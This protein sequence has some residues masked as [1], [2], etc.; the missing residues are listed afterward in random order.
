MRLRRFRVTEYI[1]EC[2]AMFDLFYFPS[3][4]T[5]K[6]W[7]PCILNMSLQN[8]VPIGLCFSSY[9]I[10][11]S[12]TDA[13]QI[14]ACEFFLGTLTI[15]PNAD[16]DSISLEGLQ[17]AGSIHVVDSAH[18]QSISSSTLRALRWW[19][20]NYRC[21]PIPRVIFSAFAFDLFAIH[22]RCHVSSTNYI[23]WSDP[24][25]QLYTYASNISI[26]NSARNR[27]GCRWSSGHRLCR[28]EI[29]WT[30]RCSY[31]P[32]IHHSSRRF[33]VSVAG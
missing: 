13:T 30:I 31:Y 4:F 5:S 20:T 33:D 12:Q 25:S 14:S 7:I 19:P 6:S 16:T 22:E 17:T 18:L 24:G 28:V 9:F 27:R 11:Q 23:P 32:N 26:R 8:Q 29:G 21:N 3:S 10:I 15:Q 1:S 2:F